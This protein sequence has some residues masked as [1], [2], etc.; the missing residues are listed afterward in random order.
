MAVLLAICSAIAGF[1]NHAE[2]DS[3][4][5]IVH[6]K[7]EANDWVLSLAVAHDGTIFAATWTGDTIYAVNPDGTLKRKLASCDGGGRLT[8]G[9]DDTLYARCTYGTYAFDR[10][11]TLKWKKQLLNFVAEGNDDVTYA[12]GR[13]PDLSGRNLYPPESLFVLTSDGTLAPKFVA[14]YGGFLLTVSKDGETFVVSAQNSIGALAADGVLRWSASPGS[15]IT[16]LAIGDDGVIYAG[17]HL[18]AKIRDPATGVVK[19][20]V[21]PSPPVV[22]ALDPMTGAVMWS[23][24][25]AK[26][27]ICALKVGADGTVYV[28][29]YDG[30]IYALDPHSGGARWRFSTGSRDWRRSPVHALA[31]GRDGVIYAGAGRFIEAISLPK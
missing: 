2:A 9:A 24:T 23:S 10:N 15:Q 25:V 17:S 11:G 31:L 30:N 27:N 8:V 5:P 19:Y 1:T 21:G 4:R 22:Y 18:V 29:S 13:E 7:F 3:P 28:G 26:G 14:R 12:V 16:A 6:W 20:V